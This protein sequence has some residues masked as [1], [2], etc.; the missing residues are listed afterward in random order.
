[1]DTNA[2]S[3][4]IAQGDNPEFSVVIRT[5]VNPIDI[6]VQLL[7]GGVIIHNF[8]HRED[9][10]RN[11]MELHYAVPDVA[12]GDYIVRT[13]ITNSNTNVIEDTTELQLEVTPLPPVPPVDSDDDGVNDDVDNCPHNYNPLQTD[14]DGD[15]L[16]N[17]CDPDMDND[18]VPNEEDNCPRVSN[19]L[20][21][22]S[23]GDGLGNVCDPDMDD[24]D[25]PNDQDNCDRVYNP[26]QV[27]TDEDGIGDA[28]DQDDDNDGVQDEADNCPLDANPEQ[29]DGD[30]DG[31]GD[32][33]DEEDNR[34]AAQLQFA[35]QGPYDVNEGEV[36]TI[37]VTTDRPDVALQPY[38]AV[39][40]LGQ[41]SPWPVLPDEAN[42]RQVADDANTTTWEFTFSPDFTYIIHP[43]RQSGVSFFIIPENERLLN[44]IGDEPTFRITVHDVNQDPEITS[45]P[46]LQAQVGEEYN[47]D[48][49]AVDADAEDDLSF[50]LTEASLGMVIDDNSGELS[51]TPQANQAGDHDVTVRVTDGVGG[52]DTQEFA[53]RVRAVPINDADRDGIPD[54]VDNCFFV[55][56]PNQEDT[57]GDGIGD[58]CEEVVPPVDSDGDG[59]FDGVDNCPA[60]PNPDQENEDGDE[61]GDACEPDTDVD[62]V[63]DDVDNCPFVP[64][65]DQADADGDGEGD[66]CEDVV[67]LVDSDGDGV[68]DGV[69]NCP[70]VPNPDQENEDGDE[71]GDACEPDTDVDGVP[72]DV[73]NCPL[74]ANPGQEDVDAD[75]I[76]D[77]C[78]AQD[79]RDSD[80]DGVR[81]EVDNCPVI[82]N[83][84][85]ADVDG[86]GVGNACDA[87]FVNHRPL[88]LSSPET[89]AQEDALYEYQV[90]AIDLDGD[91]LLYSLERAPQGMII[92]A[93]GVVHWTSETDD[94]AFVTIVVSDGLFETRQQ[95][96]IRVNE[97]TRGMKI[98]TAALG[99]EITAAGSFVPVQVSVTNNGA[100]DLRNVRVTVTVYDLGV[101]R[102][103]T[104]FNLN[105]GRTANEQVV[106]P[107]PYDAEAGE[108]TV[109]ITVGNGLFHDTTYRQITILE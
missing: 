91:D 53:I 23:D 9:F 25:V 49:D 19:P 68:F 71:F 92:T 104:Q 90:E 7:Q 6:D 55:P 88:I 78:D 3:H 107:L 102:S 36:L 86:D 24:D 21:T 57:D 10:L 8:L 13:T 97:L 62:G 87:G 20:Q 22:D 35:P 100:V 108:Y 17:V 75:D 34:P 2:Q 43:N 58:A 69:D 30:G 46:V 76:G 44:Y 41:W 59:V 80:N 11:R 84:N 29:E 85:Q 95:Y 47:Y 72:D 31:I 5:Q 39:N 82:P 83:A 16:G 50:A 1:D 40:V 101:Q 37:T 70:A 38:Y 26:A 105:R 33:C 64:N 65:A 32:V 74:D 96:T 98:K 54:G 27:D 73:D 61:F 42:F 79:D 66:A 51:W 28:C 67:P 48:V 45:E 12:A 99:T 63:I 94:D 103:S 89:A 18:D 56:N 77:V 14:S 93:D 4:I 15:G 81:D 60:V 109:R 106:V 52:E